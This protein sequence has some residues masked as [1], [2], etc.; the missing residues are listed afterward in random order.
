LLHS[1]IWS[2]ITGNQNNH[3]GIEGQ[4]S[5]HPHSTH[6]QQLNQR[7][8]N[9]LKKM[10]EIFQFGDGKDTRYIRGGI[11]L[12]ILDFARNYVK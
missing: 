4:T 10:D 12:Q 2:G 6:P 9:L 5:G 11:L 8:Q 1:S 3:D 7:E